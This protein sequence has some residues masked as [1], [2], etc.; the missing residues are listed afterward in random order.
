MKRY[1]LMLI[2]IGLLSFSVNG[3]SQAPEDKD[4][5]VDSASEDAGAPVESG[6]EKTTETM[7]E[8]KNGAEQI[9]EGTAVTDVM[10]MRNTDAF[11]T[12]SMG[13][14]MFS[15]KKHADAV[16]DGYGIACG[17]CHHDKDGRPLDIREGDEVQGCMACHD[18]TERPRRTENM[19]KQDWDTMQLEYYYGAIHANCIDCHRTGGAGPVQCTEC[20][21]KPER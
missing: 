20:H 2:F 5:A 4:T 12:H 7:E 19:S 13:I 8:V 18:K 6:A 3:C 15:H 21:P 10:E 9:K 1:M 14:V 11:G 17:E 16:P